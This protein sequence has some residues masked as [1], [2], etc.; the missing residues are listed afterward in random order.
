M[1]T[2][3][4]NGVVHT[5]CGPDSQAIAVEDERIV[6]VGSN[7]DVLSLRKPD[8]V[9]VDLGGRSVVPG[10]ND[11]HCHIQHTGAAAGRLNLRG[12][13]SLAEIVARGR[14]YASDARLEP[15]QWIVGDGFDH[16]LFDVPELPTRAVADAIS[17]GHPVLLERICGHVGTVNTAGLRKMGFDES[18]RI[19]GGA[20]D[21]G[22]DGALNGILREN[23]LYRVTFSI[24]KAASPAALAD[25]L[26]CAMREANRF[27]VTSV[28]SDDLEATRL[29]DLE[30]AIALLR[31]DGRMTARLYEEVQTQTL[32]ELE[33][34][35]KLGRRTGDGDSWYRIGN[36]KLIL[37]GSLG[38]RTAWFRAPYPGTDDRGLNVY[39]DGDLFQ[40]VRTA[41]EG[42][43]QLAFH[44]IGDA[45][46]EQCVC[47][48]ERA[49]QENPRG[50]R[51]R[52]VH[53]QF[54][55]PALLQRIRR[56]G[57]GVDIQPAFTAS[58]RQVAQ[59]TLDASRLAGAYAWRD[60]LA[61]GIPVGA[62]SDS[63]VET[64]NP[65]WGIFCAVTRTDADG[66]PAGGW[67]PR[68]RLTVG[69]ALALYTRGGAYLSFSERE[70][71][72]LCAGMLADFAVLSED[73]FK[74]A[75]ERIAQIRVLETVVGGRSVYRE[76]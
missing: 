46:V 76:A 15:G 71:G 49:Q 11:S 28:Q 19:D 37:D 39:D 63:P 43:M 9:L 24:P 7:S 44:A 70:K 30:A 34:F 66:L 52:V 26:A 16:N 64:L 22:P 33:A 32:P 74:V 35:L 10:F 73:I 27:G 20:L 4:V 58:D 65:L 51:H 17:T 60:M 59:A 13:R 62:G 61:M 23:A 55:D 41:N 25:A 68:Q 48:V 31:T 29:D 53:C 54:A 36:I 8:S 56:A 14:A 21:V 75:P 6:A 47:A 42:G 3:Y 18:T 67:L 12:V 2:I 50:L 57:M 45:A 40:L 69:E 38:A 5:L 1:Q 72:V